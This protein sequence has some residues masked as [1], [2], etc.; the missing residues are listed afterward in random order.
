MW[1]YSL[2][3]EQDPLAWLR[4]S[5]AAIKYPVTQQSVLLLFIHMNLTLQ[6]STLANKERTPNMWFTWFS[7]W[8]K[9]HR[10]PLSVPSLG[11]RVQ[12]T[13]SCITS[14]S[15]LPQQSR[16]TSPGTAGDTKP[17][18][19]LMDWHLRSCQLGQNAAPEHRLDG[20]DESFVSSWV[21]R[22]VY[23][24]FKLSDSLI[25]LQ[26]SS[27]ASALTGV[28]QVLHPCGELCVCVCVSL[29]RWLLKWI[30]LSHH[31]RLVSWQI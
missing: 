11:H 1:R 7:A 12:N 18:G 5:K 21:I 14:M 2:S 24:S 10:I 26:F 17:L 9:G 25:V 22:L 28:T 19:C 31:V 30:D 6:I 15:A 23:S 29:I 8:R 13:S 4:F 3:Q 20:R 27:F 16:S